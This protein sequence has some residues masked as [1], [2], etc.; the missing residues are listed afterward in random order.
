M[1][2]VEEKLQA[3]RHNVKYFSKY[4]GDKKVSSVEKYAGV[5]R[6]Y[7]SRNLAIPL[8]VALKMSEYLSIGLDELTNPKARLDAEAKRAVEKLQKDEQ[9]KLNILNNGE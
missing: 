7:L 3:F 8:K 4:R 1:S 6:G 5:G 2:N 9:Q